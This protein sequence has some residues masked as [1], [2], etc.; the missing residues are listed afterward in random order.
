MV[1]SVPLKKEYVK[2]EEREPYYNQ[3]IE[4]SRFS[5]EKE[6]EKEKPQ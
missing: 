6:K 3:R 5:P 4:I 1:E 2:V